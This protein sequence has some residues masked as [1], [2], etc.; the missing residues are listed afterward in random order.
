MKAMIIGLDGATWDV[1]D[2]EFLTRFMPNLKRLKE[3]GTSGTLQSTLPPITPAAWTSCLTGVEPCHHGLVDFKRYSFSDNWLRITNSSHVRVPNLWHYL[4]DNNLRIASINVPF[5]YPAYPVNGILIGGM[6]TPGATSDFV[7]PPEF[8]ETLY[9]QIPDYDIANGSVAVNK[10]LS[11]NKAE[12]TASIEKIKRRLESRLD[13]ARLVQK[14]QQTDVMMVQFQQTDLI[15]HRCWRY[16]SPKLRDNYPYQR[17]KIFELFVKLDQ[18]IGELLKMADKQS[19]LVAVLSDHGFGPTPWV[20]NVNVILADW[21]YIKRARPISRAIRRTRLNIRKGKGLSS[22]HVPLSIQ[23]PVDWSKTRAIV[24]QRPIYSSVHLNVK[25][26]QPGGIVP[27]GDAY[28]QLIAELKSKFEQFTNPI[29]GEKVFDKVVVPKKDFDTDAPYVLESYGDLMLVHKPHYRTSSTLKASRG[30][31]GKIKDNNLNAAWHYPNGLFILNGRGI[32]AGKTIDAN[33]CD[34]APTFYS[35]LGMPIPAEVD[36]QP[37]VGAFEQSPTIVKNRNV[38]YPE[39]FL[40]EKK[41]PIE[42]TQEEQEALA[43]Q[44]RNLGY[45]D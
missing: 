28:D 5:T 38:Q 6:G 13:L 42:E 26:R 7:Y 32:H 36:G 34:I 41:A 18:I 37:I 33:I 24:V 29:N 16:V 19:S 4:S 17:D 9:D 40:G 20:V 45:L 2:D 25:G 35:W 21:G 30:H 15:K 11:G 31:I 12:F 23:L 39:I 8:K 14:Q 22:R 44:L 1:L 27:P 10:G 3:T 43:E